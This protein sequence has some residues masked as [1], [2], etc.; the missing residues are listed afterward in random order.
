MARTVVGRSCRARKAPAPYIQ[1]QR[2]ALYKEYSDR[3]LNEG[4]AY[5]CFCSAERLAQVRLER[6]KNKLATG[7]DRFCREIPEVK[8]RELAGGG[9]P[10][11]SQVLKYRLTGKLFSMTKSTG[12]SSIQP[13]Y[14]TI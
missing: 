7:Y 4:K 10:F 9:A 14:L 12:P 1:S 11:V 5:R 13:T 8:Q 6:E 2:C 3:L